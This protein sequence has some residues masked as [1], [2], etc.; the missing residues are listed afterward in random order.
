MLLHKALT[1]VL[2]IAACAVIQIVD[3]SDASKSLTGSDFAAGIA[4]GTTFVK[5]FSPRCGHCLAL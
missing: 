1:T 2:T 5:F 3:A 4:K